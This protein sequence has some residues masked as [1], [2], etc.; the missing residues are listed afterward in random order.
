M[1][2]ITVTDSGSYLFNCGKMS[3]YLEIYLKAKLRL[4]SLTLV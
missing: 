2:Y 4:T 1:Y 3:T